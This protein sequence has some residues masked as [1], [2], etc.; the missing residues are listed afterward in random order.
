MAGAEMAAGVGGAAFGSIAA[1]IA[2]LAAC[3]VA[4]NAYSASCSSPQTTELFAEDREETL[5]HWT[6]IADGTAVG[7]GV[8]G[9]VIGGSWWPLIGALLVV[10]MMH[11][12]YKHAV[13]RGLRSRAPE[14][15]NP[16]L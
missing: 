3:D 12:Y 6:L 10:A 2:F 5:M 8:L 9:S 14:T 1:G 4:F 13:R 11:Y 15:P 16:E 7:F